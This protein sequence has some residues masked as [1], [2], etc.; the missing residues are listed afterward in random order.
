M[1]VVCVSGNA[2]YDVLF[3]R[4][5]PNT[6]HFALVACARGSRAAAK[7]REQNIE[8]APCENGVMLSSS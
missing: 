3:E 4:G 7:E 8:H 1:G 5:V 6:E 2:Q